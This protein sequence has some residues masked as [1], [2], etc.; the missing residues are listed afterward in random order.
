MELGNVYDDS[1]RTFLLD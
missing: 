1:V